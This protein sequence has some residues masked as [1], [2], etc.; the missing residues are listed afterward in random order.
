[1]DSPKN[2]I[3]RRVIAPLAQ[4]E[5]AQRHGVV[6]P[7]AIVLFGPPGTGKTTFARGIASRLGWPF[8]EVFPSRLA[9]DP[10][11]LAAAL[12][13]TFG[14]LARL[15][16]V[17]VFI[18]EVEE[19]A[20]VRDGR[21]ISPMH[22]VT[23]ELLKLIPAFRQH[24]TR[25]LVCATNSL[26]S[27]DPAFLRPGRFDS[28]IPIGPPDEVA[29]RA[30]WTRYASEDAVDIERLAQMSKRL[31]SAEIEYC[32]R[33]AAQIAFERYLSDATA[34][35]TDRTAPRTDDYLEVLSKLQPGVSEDMLNDF[36]QD[37]GRFARL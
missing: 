8:V 27:L 26:R 30:I 17:L 2:I 7:Q 22:G 14:E 10:A 16:R 9:S 31:T 20:G 34:T 33:A 12:R 28:I 24:D 25:L 21:P 23:N 13:D 11:G 5:H 18:D 4:P 35:T 1:M 36:L 37:A 29:R 3:E 6:P 19:I 32:A 15:E